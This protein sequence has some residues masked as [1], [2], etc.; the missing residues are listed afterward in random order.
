MG[1]NPYSLEILRSVSGSGLVSKRSSLWGLG[2][3]TASAG[4][5][6]QNLPDHSMLVPGL[7]PVRSHVGTA[8]MI[9]KRLLTIGILGC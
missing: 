7:P 6:N 3:E 1:K 4:L 2:A 9:L 5:S 8:G